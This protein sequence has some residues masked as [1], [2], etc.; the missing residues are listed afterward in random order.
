MN[1]LGRLEQSHC[2]GC[3]LVVG[4]PSFRTANQVF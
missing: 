3:S 4:E 1:M 2:E